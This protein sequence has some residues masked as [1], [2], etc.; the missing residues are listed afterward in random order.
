M[1]RAMGCWQ[2]LLL[3]GGVTL[4]GGG[5]AGVPLGGSRV[6]VCG[7]QLSGADSEALKQR[8]AQIMSRGLPKQK[9]I[10]GVKQVIV[11][12]S[13]KGGVGK[14]TTAVNLALGLA[15]NDSSKAVGLLDVDVYGP[16]IPKMMNLK[17]NPELSQN[18]LMRPLLNYGIAC[19]SM[20]FLIEETA[21]VVWRGLMVMSAI[22]KLLRQVDWGPLDYLV[23][24]TP[25]GTGDVQLSISQNIPIS[26]AVIV[27][28]PQDIALVDA[29]KGAEMFR[30]VHV[31]AKAYLRIA[32]EVV[33][34]L[35]P[36]LKWRAIQIHCKLQ[37]EH[38]IKLSLVMKE[39]L[40]RKGDVPGPRDQ[41]SK[42]RGSRSYADETKYG[43]LRIL[44]KPLIFTEGYSH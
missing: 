26:G 20:G 18:N 30:K 28:T 27:S 21:P 36:P 41:T 32:A 19:M 5:G 4:R 6:L 16:S 39:C 23:V 25:P 37:Q 14:S 17:G 29:H 40:S 11:V 7:R 31:P 34:R 3:F 33:R 43:L 38:V 1:L 10:E 15:A 8:R 2:R 12:A 9:P 42:I 35:P 13:G 22:E 24:D 44:I